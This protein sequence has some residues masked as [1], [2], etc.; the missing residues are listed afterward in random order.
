MRSVSGSEDEDE[1][2]RLSDIGP[3]FHQILKC[4]EVLFRI[5]FSIVIDFHSIYLDELQC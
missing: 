1:D 4:R 3:H 2:G 5:S